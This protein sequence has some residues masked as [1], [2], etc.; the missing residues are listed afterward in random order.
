V[1]PGC[2]SQSLGSA[3]GNN[4]QFLDRSFFEGQTLWDSTALLPCVAVAY[5]F[6]AV[7]SLSALFAGL[8][9]TVPIRANEGDDSW[10]PTTRTNPLNRIV[11]LVWVGSCSRSGM[12]SPRL[13]VALNVL[14]SVCEQ[15]HR[16]LQ[17]RIYTRLIS[18]RRDDNVW[19]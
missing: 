10:G 9:L 5:K 2:G 4:L 8:L 14:L 1:K 19:R 6:T 11:S 16:S 12:M 13:S 7:S 15:L 3:F 18:S 17:N